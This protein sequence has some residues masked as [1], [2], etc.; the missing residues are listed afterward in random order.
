MFVCLEFFVP[1]ENFWLIWRHYHSRWR[2]A[3][4]DLCSAL[5]AIEQWGF[6]SVSH[7]LWHGASVYNGHLQ[8]PVTLALNAERVAVRLRSVTT[9]IR[10]PN[11][12]LTE[13]TL[14]PTV[15]SPR[16]HLISAMILFLII[17]VFI[18]NWDVVIACGW[19]L[20]TVRPQKLIRPMVGTYREY[21]TFES[22]HPFLKSSRRTRNSLLPRFWQTVTTWFCDLG[23]LRAG[24]EHQTFKY[25]ANITSTVPPRR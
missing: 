22:G 16:Q 13:R 12:P 14:K 19:V 8:W 9:G 10:T 6:F 20:G 2:A 11:L 4:F 1:L 17:F 21:N 5:L 24:F 18:E 15:P 7:L 3:N 23:L 25:E